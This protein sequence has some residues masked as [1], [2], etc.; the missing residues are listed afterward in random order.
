[1]TPGP[2]NRHPV[3]V[4]TARRESPLVTALVTPVAYVVG[5]VFIAMM[6]YRGHA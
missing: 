1:M 5:F 4:P 2:I 3:P 6:F